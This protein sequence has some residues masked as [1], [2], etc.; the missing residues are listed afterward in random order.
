MPRLFF[1]RL[2]DWAGYKIRVPKLKWILQVLCLLV[3]SAAVFLEARAQDAG[4]DLKV[5]PHPL[6]AEKFGVGQ[7]VPNVIVNDLSDHELNLGRL[8]GNKPLVIF[9]FSAFCPVSNK[10]G[11]EL[12]RLENDYAA[13][14]IS[15]L[16]VAPTTSETASD[17]TNYIAKYH[18][19]SPVVKD[20]HD[21]LVQALGA[22]TTTE[23]FVLDAARKLIYRGAINDQYGLGYSRE[24]P[25]HTYLRDALEAMLHGQSPA[26]AATTAPGCD[27]DLPAASS[28]DAK[29]ALTYYHQISRI[30]Q[31][32]CI[33]CHHSGGIG[34]FSL[35]TLPDVVG[36]SGRIRQA[37]KRGVMPPWFAAP[38]P[39]Q[40]ES[41]WANDCSLSQ[42]DK[43]NL[44]AWI[45]A[46]CPAGD[47][48]DAPVPRVFS[49][50]WKIGEP[51]AVLQI[52]EPVPVQ[53][54]GFMHYQYRTIE[55]SFPEDRWVQAYQIMPT[56]RSVVHHV[57]VSLET[58]GEDADSLLE[59]G[60]TG[61]WAVYVPGFDSRVYPPGFA[62]KLP[63]GTKLKFQIHY[64]PNGHATE[65]QVKIGL[66][67]AKQPPQH[68]IHTLGIPQFKLDIPPGVHRHLEI[69]EYHVANDMQVTGYQAHTHLRG[70]AFRYQLIKTN[71]ETET[72]LD[73]PR[74]DFNW[75]LQYNY[76][77][78]KLIPAG[79][80]IKVFAVYDN[81][82]D[83]PANPDPTKEVKWGY[84]TFKEM[85]IG[86]VE[87]Y[88][89]TPVGM[90]NPQNPAEI[91]TR[92]TSL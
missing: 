58:N 69:A 92:K 28:A 81:S 29:P 3:L 33:N 27:L 79:S 72:L 86:Y 37:V 14:G 42:A 41:P 56:A 63:A 85:M 73:L 84:Q 49:S 52:P 91:S 31:A 74:Y 38:Q 59:S 53:A 11:P 25:S 44:L 62:R 12:A 64:T 88:R 7:I 2:N 4:Q 54:E 36:N 32:N 65:D 43:A 82:A 9:I 45:E 16:L 61:F 40:T 23:T 17:L 26:I 20:A 24:A 87:Y 8:Q 10:Y 67:F 68:E 50:N 39:G 77:H 5:S 78:P 66:V 34:P 21:V 15:F 46:N 80:T 90:S 71:G 1:P 75:Q 76:I 6:P 30:L 55:T 70:I 89:P 13:R 35:E 60:A 83:N 22:T 57:I 47:P 48:A 51:D 18:L 19:K